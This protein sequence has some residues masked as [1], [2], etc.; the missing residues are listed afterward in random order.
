MCVI[1]N[2]VLLDS[3]VT[4][5]RGIVRT[6]MDGMGGSFQPSHASHVRTRLS[7]GVRTLLG[8][9]ES[10]PVSVAL[11]KK[12][13]VSVEAVSE[14]HGLLVQVHVGGPIT[15]GI[16]ADAQQLLLGTAN[17]EQH[18]VVVINVERTR[19]IDV[20]FVVRG[21]STLGARAHAVVRRVPPH[22]VA[23]ILLVR[24]CVCVQ[25][26]LGPLAA[27][28]LGPCP[29]AQLGQLATL[30]ARG[31]TLDLRGVGY[32]VTSLLG[33]K[34]AHVV[35]Q[36]KPYVTYAGGQQ[37]M[38]QQ[39]EDTYVDVSRGGARKGS[40]SHNANVWLAPTPLLLCVAAD[41]EP[42][43]VALASV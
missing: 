5:V 33:A 34:K 27:A 4:T 17:P 35:L 1:K 2:I 19:R 41:P 43:A 7:D 24:A 21:V 23:Q 42:G 40:N 36:D 10:A 32:A 9:T 39:I 29:E 12:R 13:C 26:Q 18:L 16:L 6:E 3:I 22:D 37:R 30:R 14:E 8:L 28:L 20:A 15:T 25:G 38:H 31:I 11:D